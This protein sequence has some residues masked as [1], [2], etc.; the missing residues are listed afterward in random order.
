[1]PTTQIKRGMRLRKRRS[2]AVREVAGFTTKPTATSPADGIRRARLID[3]FG[4]EDQAETRVKVS[5]ITKTYEPY[6][7]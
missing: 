7:Y 2:G 4:I 1:M 5:Q 3:P 6:T